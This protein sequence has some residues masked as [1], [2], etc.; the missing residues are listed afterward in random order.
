MA[1]RIKPGDVIVIRY[2]GPKGGPG[3]QEM[4]APTSAL[5]GQGL[6]ESVGLLTD[7]RFSGGTW[8]M[9]VGHV[10]PEAFLG[11]TIALVKEGDSIT[12]DAKK[13]LLQLKSREGA[14]KT[15]QEWRAPKP[16]YTKGLLA[17]YTRLVSS[18]SQGA[19]DRRG[20]AQKLDR[21]FRNSISCGVLARPRMAL[22]M[23]KAP[24]AQHHIAMKDGVAV[25][26]DRLGEGVERPGEFTGEGLV[27]QQLAVL[28]RQIGEH[29]LHRQHAAV[30]SGGNCVPRRLQGK[31]IGGES[32]RRAAKHVAR[33]LIEQN[34][35]REA[36]S[37]GFF[38]A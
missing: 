7:G 27:G 37:G 9:V 23:W 19:V 15:A 36:V 12:I 33:E 34:D 26:V 16:R 13:R 11:G 25:R 8:G 31:W 10:A 3:M 32:A 35:E 28:E 2:E 29:A 22:R 4:L 1:K 24:E 21:P 17:K 38:Q 18:A 20:V 6:G 30:E 5:I 14:R